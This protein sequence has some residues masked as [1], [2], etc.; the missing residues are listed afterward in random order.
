MLATYPS[1]TSQHGLHTSS[2]SACPELDL[3]ALRG[4]E[5][6]TYIRTNSNA[7]THQASVLWRA[8]ISYIECKPGCNTTLILVYKDGGNGLN[9][10]GGLLMCSSCELQAPSQSKH[11]GCK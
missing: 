3:I 6:W 10:G 7:T 8:D 1:S 4:N 2:N 11:S 9:E 5:C